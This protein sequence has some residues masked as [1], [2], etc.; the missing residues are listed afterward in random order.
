MNRICRVHEIRPREV[1]LRTHVWVDSH[2]KASP[3]PLLAQLGVLAKRKNQVVADYQAGP[4]VRWI[5]Q[6]L[7]NGRATTLRTVIVTT[8]HDIAR[9]FRRPVLERASLR[10]PA[11]KGN[12]H[13]S[14][15][16]NRRRNR[17]TILW[18]RKTRFK[19]P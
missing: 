10:S 9:E 16:C 17:G 6:V 11:L 7:E 19:A 1:D 5:A 18:I 3:D 12:I 15:F 14:I 2:R 4:V 13:R 8:E